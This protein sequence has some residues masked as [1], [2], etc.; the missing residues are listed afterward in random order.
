MRIPIKAPK[1]APKISKSSIF[2]KAKNSF[3]KINSD[4]E[5][6]KNMLNSG[7]DILLENTFLKFL[8]DW[9]NDLLKYDAKLDIENKLKENEKLSKEKLLTHL[10]NELEKNVNLSKEQKEKINQNLGNEYVQNFTYNLINKK[11]NDSEKQKENNFEINAK[12]V[13]EVGIE[14]AK[15]P[16]PMGVTKA[17]AKK[18]IHKMMK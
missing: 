2:S 9:L 5:K 8:Q 15:N 4:L 17:V 11:M 13:V 10:T 18:T 14:I 16:T 7:D 12:D 3:A 6:Q 1:I